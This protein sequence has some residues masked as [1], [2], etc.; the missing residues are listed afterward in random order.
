MAGRSNRVLLV[1]QPPDG[2]IPQH[3]LQ[4]ARGL[5]ERGYEMA[6]AGPPDASIRAEVEA[7]P[8]RFVALPIKGDMLAPRSD[9][10][11]LRALTAAIR[12]LGS[13]LVHTHG[14]K[15]GLLG[16]LAA[17]RAG[18]P[19]IYTPNSL[20]YRTQM[21]RPRR[22]A[23]TR[24]IVNRA[25]ERRLGRGT[26]A[27]I[28]VAA[29]EREA[30]I[31]DGLVSADRA[32]L[33]HNGAQADASVAP[34]PRL[35]EFAAGEPL[36]GFVAGLR[37]QKGLPDLLG[38]LELLAARGDPARFAIVGNG[39]LEAEVRERLAAGPAGPTTLLSAF[40]APVEPY[41]AALDVF[42]LPSYW[43]GLPLAVLE[44]M[45]M[46]LPVVAT[47]VNGTPDAVA[48]GETGLLVAPHDPEGLATAIATLMGDATRRREMG[49]CGRR[50]AADRFTIERMVDE[51]AAV[52]D[53]VLRT[54]RGSREPKIA[55]R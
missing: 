7:G 2:G 26:A 4:L 17:R 1:F 34:D 40:E 19:S 47:A 39:P 35:V 32:H 54:S 10:A 37:D 29:E 14:Q 48:D 16:R 52:Y 51:T 11:S 9:A 24:M 38:A 25:V 3:V 53:L 27:F 44:A 46:G 8:G 22:C 20:V 45:H 33:V 31:A 43:E 42:V 55:P 18:V 13:D 6:V 30:A 41:L 49:A 23:R 28:A 36:A 21:L 15:A 12:G 50:R 5:S